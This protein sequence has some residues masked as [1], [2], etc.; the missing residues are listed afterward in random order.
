[1]I[2]ILII[3]SSNNPWGLG[4]IHRAQILLKRFELGVAKRAKWA[5]ILALAS[6]HLIRA[7]ETVPEVCFRVE[8]NVMNHTIVEGIPEVAHPAGSGAGHAKVVT[9]AGEIGLTGHTDGDIVR[10]MMHGVTCTT[11]V[12][13]DFYQTASAL[14]LPLLGHG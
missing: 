6:S 10:D 5:A 2:R 1:M 4:S 8:L 12:T 14:W 13:I 3:P 9:I 11:V 7:D